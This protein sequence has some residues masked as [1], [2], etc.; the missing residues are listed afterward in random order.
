MNLRPTC[1]QDEPFCNIY[2]IGDQLEFFFVLGWPLVRGI[3]IDASELMFVYGDVN[4]LKTFCE[5]FSKIYNNSISL[6][7]LIY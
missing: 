5:N 3:E 4:F 2:L 6:F 7:C 1:L